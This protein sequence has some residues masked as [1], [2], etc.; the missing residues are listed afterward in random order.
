MKD[1][2][3]DPGAIFYIFISTYYELSSAANQRVDSKVGNVFKVRDFTSGRSSVNNSFYMIKR[4]R[5]KLI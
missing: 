3:P 4:E 5:D 1:L 2:A